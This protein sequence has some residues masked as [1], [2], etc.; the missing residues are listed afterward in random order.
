MAQIVV[1]ELLQYRNP[2]FI[3]AVIYDVP[4]GFLSIFDVGSEPLN[5]TEIQELHMALRD[6][7]VDDNRWMVAQV[8][9]STPVPQLLFIW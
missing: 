4:S 1:E 8:P 9:V 2:S 7:V 6:H 5:T 3:N